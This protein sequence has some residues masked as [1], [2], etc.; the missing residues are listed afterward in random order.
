MFENLPKE[1]QDQIFMY[2]RTKTER[3]DKVIHQ[4]RFI[5]ILDQLEAKYFFYWS[6]YPENWWSRYLNAYRKLNRRPSRKEVD[7]LV[8][9]GWR[10]YCQI[11][12]HKISKK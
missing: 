1:I 8:E 11:H 10:R 3:F 5:P 12:L 2:D 4:I 9:M 7:L 6:W